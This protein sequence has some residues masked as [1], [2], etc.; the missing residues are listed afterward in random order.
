VEKNKNELQKLPEQISKA[1]KDTPGRKT[2]GAEQDKNGLKN[3]Q[4][5]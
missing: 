3:T 5:K 1:R 4:R 2:A